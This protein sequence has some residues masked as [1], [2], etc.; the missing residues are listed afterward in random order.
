MIGTRLERTREV[1]GTKITPNQDEAME[2][3]IFI[4]VEAD[5]FSVRADAKGIDGNRT[6]FRF[7]ERGSCFPIVRC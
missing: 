1:Y 7:Q 4:V 6:V 2:Q 3:R 5:D